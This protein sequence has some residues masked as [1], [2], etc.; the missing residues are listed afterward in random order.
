[1][2][3]DGQ[4]IERLREYPPTLRP[5]TRAMPIAERERGLLR[6]EEM[7]GGEGCDAA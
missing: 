3:N 4:S 7:T 1:M 2:T 6:G 5:E